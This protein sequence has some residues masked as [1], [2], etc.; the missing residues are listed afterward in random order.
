MSSSK[1]LSFALVASAI[2]MTLTGCVASSD[3]A[4]EEL[5]SLDGEEE[6]LGSAQDALKA[7]DLLN[8]TQ[9]RDSLRA[10]WKKKLNTTQNADNNGKWLTSGADG[11]SPAGLYGALVLTQPNGITLDQA[12]RTYNKKSVTVSNGLDCITDNKNGLNPNLSCS[13]TTSITKLVSTTHGVENAI[14]L[15]AS[16]AIKASATL[17]GTGAE[18]TTTLS[19]NYN[20]TW[21]KSTTNSDS[22]TSSYTGNCNTTVP[23]GKVYQCIITGYVR[24]FKVP[25]KVVAAV[26]GFTETWFENKVSGHYNYALGGGSAFQLIRDWNLAGS[27]SSAFSSAGY[28]QKGTLTASTRGSFVT[29]VKDITASYVPPPPPP[30]GAKSPSVPRPEAESVIYDGPVVQ[31]MRSTGDSLPPGLELESDEA[32]GDSN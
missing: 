22:T 20:H 1:S 12:N 24:D 30:A 8:S 18:A 19:V 21:S 26:S 15:G 16:V 7:T 11:D 29:Q 27:S 23:K 25:Y 17:F 13:I 32:E 28:T 31:V 14:N 3:V 4:D 2:A 6:N 5:D 9:L 10:M